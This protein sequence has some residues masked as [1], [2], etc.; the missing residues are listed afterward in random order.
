MRRLSIKTKRALVEGA[1]VLRR[2]CGSC[3][4]TWRRA[5]RHCPACG[6]SGAHREPFTRGGRVVFAGDILVDF[7]KCLRVFRSF[8]DEGVP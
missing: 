1:C 8:T 2:M 7:A 5:R 3:G 4:H 6:A